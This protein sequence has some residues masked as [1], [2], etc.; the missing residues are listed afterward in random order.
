MQFVSPSTPATPPVA[1]K[2]STAGEP[3]RS[4]TIQVASMKAATLDLL[5]ES[6]VIRRIFRSNGFE[7]SRLVVSGSSSSSPS[8]S[9]APGG[10]SATILPDEVRVV[11]SRRVPEDIYVQLRPWQRVN[12]IPGRHRIGHKD[13]LGM[14]MRQAATAFPDAFNFVPRTFVLPLHAAEFRAAAQQQER[15]ATKSAE[16]PFQTADGNIW[17]SK[18]PASSQGRGIEVFRGTHSRVQDCIEFAAAVVQSANTNCTDTDSSGKSS[19]GN[20]TVDQVKS[21]IEIDEGMV[22][23]G[24]GERSCSSAANEKV[25]APDSPGDPVAGLVVQEYIKDPYLIRGLKFD[26]RVYVLVATGVIGDERTE[27]DASPLCCFVYNDGIVKFCSSEFSLD[28]ETLGESFRHL[29]NYAL[30]KHN[31][32]FDESVEEGE[33]LIQPFCRFA[34]CCL[35]LCSLCMTPFES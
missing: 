31:E 23:Q 3:S 16:Q 22:M 20:K 15:R 17:I 28:D 29:A 24:Q 34:F 27:D 4:H 9:C 25:A 19:G 5:W 12:H 2:S 21:Q 10:S 32:T 8:F 7:V 1:S 18:P 33:G 6:D 30:N 14:L 35:C 13:S 11:W 26:L